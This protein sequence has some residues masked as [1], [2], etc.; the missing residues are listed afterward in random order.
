MPEAFLE[1]IFGFENLPD[2]KQKVRKAVNCIS[3][4]FVIREDKSISIMHKSV[5]DW[6][7]DN[8]EHD[9]SVNVQYGHQTLF[10]LCVRKLDEIKENGVA[11]KIISGDT[12]MRYAIKYFIQHMSSMQGKSDKLESF[13]S[14][15]VSDLEVLLDSVCL[16]VNLTLN[17]LTSLANNV[18]FKNVSEKTRTT[19][20]RLSSLVKKF[21]FFLRENPRT[22]LQNIVNEG[23]NELSNSASTLLETRYKHIGC[24]EFLNKRKNNEALEAYWL[25][26]GILTGLDISPKN[27]YLV[28]SYEEGGIELF[29]LPTGKSMWKISDFQVKF[30]SLSCT[31]YN[32]CMLPHC[33][34]FRR[35][36]DVIL[37]STLSPVLTL[38]G[39]FTPGPFL[40]DE[41]CSEFTNCCFSSD[42]SKMVT[43]YDDKLIIWKVLSGKMER[44]LQC[45]SLFSLSLTAS[46]SFLGTTDAGGAIKV[47][48]CRNDYRVES[49]K[50]DSLFP[51]EIVSTY[52][53]N[54]WVCSVDDE[55]VIVSDT[56]KLQDLDCSVTEICLPHSYFYSN[57]LKTFFLN[58][59]QSWF[60]KFKKKFYGDTTVGPGYISISDESVLIYCTYSKSLQIFNTKKLVDME[61][62]PDWTTCDFY[63][64]LSLNGGFA[65]SLKSDRLTVWN[66]ESSLK[67]SIPYVKK[68]NVSP[69]VVKDGVILFGDHDTPE[70]WNVDVTERYS[71]FDQLARTKDCVSVS[72]EII[73]CHCLSSV[74][75]FNVFTEK[76]MSKTIFDQDC[77]SY[78]EFSAQYHVLAHNVCK[79]V[80]AL[81][82]DGARLDEWEDVLNKHELCF[83]AAFSP[84]ANRLAMQKFRSNT[85][86]I[87]DVLSISVLFEIDLPEEGN[88]LQFKFFD[89][90]NLLF[91]LTICCIW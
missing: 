15:Y 42:S 88:E 30:S 16:N 49:L 70:L 10:N 74:I 73:A 50:C 91:H 58:R 82:K 57:N 80:Y 62:P 28:C 84:Q 59:E 87:F 38:Q 21:A 11:D 27:D 33:T 9:Y 12:A 41:G 66:I 78:I 8:T 3:S 36:K 56:L 26:S 64:S 86:L 47:Y 71:R 4:L 13:V 45:N 85:L 72:D 25:L 32:P 63:S 1:T 37:P 22:F 55:L 35:C 24:L 75:F 61:E 43:Y 40:C 60:S 2:T 83:F 6:L 67:S 29:S 5:R 17:N 18:V 46:G 53:Q 76:I 34:V 51:I 65:Y 52:G 77:W 81:W 89:D 79:D 20:K 44:T 39:E 90:K 19:V 14:K 68:L 48:D 54:S 31:P 7:V 23:G 69:P